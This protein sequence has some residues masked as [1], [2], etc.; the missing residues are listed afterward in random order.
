[1]AQVH[2]LAH[3]AGDYVLEPHRS[4]P[5]RK[6]KLPPLDLLGAAN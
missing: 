5:G 2:A 6:L 3:G 1:M 4:R